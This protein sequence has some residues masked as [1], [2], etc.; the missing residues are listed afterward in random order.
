M[1]F[2]FNA[3]DHDMPSFENV[4]PG[5][6]HATITAV[7]LVQSKSESAG[8]MFAITFEIDANEHPEW[9]NRKIPVNL[10]INHQSEKTAAIARGQLAKILMVTDLQAIKD[11][12]ELLGAQ[13]QVMLRMGKARDGYEARSE[14]RDCKHKSG[15]AAKPAAAANVTATGSKAAAPAAA[16]NG[17]KKPAWK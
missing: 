9:A 16:G 4:P 17:K 1:K 10:C 8:E 13:L 12:T 11:T 2:E 6:Y 14:Y 5:W 3:A 15:E 7:D